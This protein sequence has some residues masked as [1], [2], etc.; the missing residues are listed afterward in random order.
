MIGAPAKRHLNGSMCVLLAGPWWLNTD[1]W[2]VR[3]VSL[4]GIRI[5]I[6][7]TPYIS[8]IFQGGGGPDPLSPTLDPHM[9][10]LYT[11]FLFRYM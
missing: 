1:S 7:K 9:D 5:N 10:W 4:Q 11:V 8:V 3:F 6:A 2:V